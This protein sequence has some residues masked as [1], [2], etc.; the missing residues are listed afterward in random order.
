MD[1]ITFNKA[2][3]ALPE[4]TEPAQ[5]EAVRFLVRGGEAYALDN[6]GHELWRAAV[7]GSVKRGR[8]RATVTLASGDVL[9]VRNDCGCGSSAR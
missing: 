8:H 4:G 7:T 1:T 6:H 2:S 3:V 9:D 5:L